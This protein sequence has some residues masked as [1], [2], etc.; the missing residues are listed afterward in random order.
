MNRFRFSI[1]WVAC[2]YAISFLQVFVFDSVDPDDARHNDK[3]HRREDHHTV[4]LIAGVVPPLG[5]HLVAEK[6]AGSE[7]F[8]EEG[9]DDQDHAVAES[10][11]DA[12]EEGGPGTVVE[13][14][15]F[16][17]AHDDTVGDDQPDEHRQGFGDV[18]GVGFQHLIDDYHQRRY[19]HELHDYADR[20]R[21]RV[22]KE[23][24]YHVGE[25]EHGRHR[26]GHHDGRLHFRRYGKRRTDAEHLHDHGIVFR[27]GVD[28][29]DQA[30]FPVHCCASFPLLIS[31]KY[32]VYGSSEF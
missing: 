1:F 23:G 4:V 25:C 12:V 17:S 5:E 10:V 8:T 3:R 24:Y 31:L 15:G 18:V 29:G 7:E 6:C 19:Y 2:R 20:L 21:N 22:A 14:E 28:E 27:Q 9:D 30:L 26:D 32:A 16:K 11:A 13:R